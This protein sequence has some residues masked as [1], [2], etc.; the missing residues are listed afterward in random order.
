MAGFAAAHGRRHVSDPT[1]FKLLVKRL[2]RQ[3]RQPAQ[4]ARLQLVDHEP[5][6]PHET[7]NSV[8]LACPLH[9]CLTQPNTSPLR[10]A[11]TDQAQRPPRETGSGCES[12]FRRIRSMETA[13][14][15]GGSCGS[16]GRQSE[17]LLWMDTSHRLASSRLRTCSETIVWPMPPPSVR[18]R[19]HAIWNSNSFIE[20]GSSMASNNPAP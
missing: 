12:N 16:A 11:H 7:K 4:A 19:R 15:G 10:Q 20:E 8:S 14:R 2:C 5:H 18:M 17:L 9:P 3:A 13:T 6:E 1:P